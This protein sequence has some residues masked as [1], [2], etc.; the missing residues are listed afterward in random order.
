ML[1][2]TCSSLGLGVLQRQFTRGIRDG[3]DFDGKARTR[4]DVFV[5]NKVYIKKA[6]RSLS[7]S[8]EIDF[9]EALAPSLEPK[10]EFFLLFFISLEM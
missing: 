4:F 10:H 5:G 9:P 2:G 7:G 3:I 8:Q 1:P 6:V